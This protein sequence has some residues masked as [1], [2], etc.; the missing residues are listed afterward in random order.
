MK[1]LGSQSGAVSYPWL[2]SSL[3]LITMNLFLPDWLVWAGETRA[4]GIWLQSAPFP[5]SGS[6]VLSESLFQIFHIEHGNENNAYLKL[7]TALYIF[8]WVHDKFW[9]YLVPSMGSNYTVDKSQVKFFIKILKC[10][11]YIKSIW[12]RIKHWDYGNSGFHSLYV[13]GIEP[14][15][16]R[17]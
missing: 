17:D 8:L 9:Y 11:Y 12:E 13:L 1:W 4:L 15:G 6:L 3:S 2:W 10:I 14:Q 5:S 7:L 16:L